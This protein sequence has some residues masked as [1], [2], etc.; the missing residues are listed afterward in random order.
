MTSA[1]ARRALLPYLPRIRSLRAA[2][3][4]LALLVHSQRP[5]RVLA[6]GR[7]P[8]PGHGPASCGASGP[9][10]ESLKIWA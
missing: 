10:S 3:V 7:G 4:L 2:K 9:D 1:Q 8:C 5:R 6:L